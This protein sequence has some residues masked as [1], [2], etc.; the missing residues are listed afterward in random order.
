MKGGIKTM[1]KQNYG[2]IENSLYELLTKVG[3]RSKNAMPK[4]DIFKS[5]LSD[6]KSNYGLEISTEY[7]IQLLEDY[8]N[9][10]RSKASKKAFDFLNRNKINCKM[11]QRNFN[12][13]LIKRVG[14][15]ELN[16]LEQEEFNLESNFGFTIRH[17]GNKVMN[18]ISF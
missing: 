7:L 8:G 1:N 6:L 3:K 2:E 16:E 17:D 15:G 9:I 12:H 13:R 10:D 18:F 5:L 14:Y 4:G 11:D